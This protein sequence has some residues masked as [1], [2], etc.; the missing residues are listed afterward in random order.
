[1]QQLVWFKKTLVLGLL[2]LTLSGCNYTTVN[3]V[4]IPRYMGLWYQ[5]S[6]NPAFFNEGLVGVTANYTLNA[7]GTVTV[8]NQ[9]FQDTLDGEK[10]E[11]TGVA[12]VFDE[13][14]NAALRVTFPGQ[15]ELPYPNYLIVVLD[16]VDY[17][18]AVVTDPLQT[19]LFVLSRTPQMDEGLYQNILAELAVKEIDTSKLLLTP[20]ATP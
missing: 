10:S 3:Y 18:Y 14:T 8:L 20:Q 6:A 1:M 2:V 5:I 4:D 17:Q 9:G 11:I 7:D 16:E 19:T 15:P 13:A 12:E